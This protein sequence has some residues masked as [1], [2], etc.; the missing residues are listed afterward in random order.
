M[1]RKEIKIKSVNMVGSGN[2]HNVYPA[3]QN[4][5]IVT[6]FIDTSIQKVYNK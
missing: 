1:I 5:T 4:M 6:L 3:F 2:I